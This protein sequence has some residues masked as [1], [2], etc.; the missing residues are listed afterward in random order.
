MRS[1]FTGILW[2]S[3][4]CPDVALSPAFALAARE[5]NKSLVAAGPGIHDHVIDVIANIEAAAVYIDLGSQLY[6]RRPGRRASGQ[7]REVLE[8]QVLH[9]RGNL[10]GGLSVDFHSCQP[11]RVAR[12]TVDTDARKHITGFKHDRGLPLG[13]NRNDLDRRREKH[14]RA[15]V[16]LI[17]SDGAVW[18]AAAD[19]D[20]ERDILAANTRVSGCVILTSGVKGSA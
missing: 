13:G 12:R 5:R 1:A 17:I 9:A 15:E 8:H 16:V 6:A 20:V 11:E 2:S 4:P 7:V 19:R 10:A 14:R 3:E 18:K